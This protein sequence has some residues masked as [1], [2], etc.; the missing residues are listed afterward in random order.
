MRFPIFGK[1]TTQSFAWFSKVR[2]PLK[3]DADTFIFRIE[4]E[5]GVPR[6]TT[7]VKVINAV[8]SATKGELSERY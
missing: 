2:P 8:F 1:T 3:F 6:G 7:G 5:G 4:K